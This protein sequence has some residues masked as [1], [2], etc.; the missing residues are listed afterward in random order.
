MKN[1][2]I[3]A[4]CLVLLTLLCACRQQ[5]LT[6]PAAETVKSNPIDNSI[7]D[8]G[9]ARYLGGKV[10]ISCTTAPCEGSSN[11]HCQVTSNTTGKF[12][13]TCSGCKMTLTFDVYHSSIDIW[14]QI[15]REDLHLD[16]LYAFV[17]RKHGETIQGFNS[18]QFNFQPNATSILYTYELSDGSEETILYSNTYDTAGRSDKTYEIDC[19]GTCGC[20]EI[21]DFSTN[22]AQCSCED[23]LMTVTVKNTKN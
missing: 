20:R 1:Y 23:C 17:Q 10:G 15:Y 11:A 21:Y 3:I 4:C 8:R 9:G 12:E 14:E 18:V 2:P 5:E 7:F 13:C 22:Q 19:T 6:T 16:D